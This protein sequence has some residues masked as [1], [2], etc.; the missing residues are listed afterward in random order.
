VHPGKIGNHYRLKKQR[1]QIRDRAAVC[2]LPV[3][4]HFGGNAGILEKW[5]LISDQQSMR[6][7]EDTGVMGLCNNHI[8]AVKLKWIISFKKPLFQHSTIPSFHD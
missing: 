3:G 7:G 6:I 5:V 1:Y 4:L 2:L 8:L